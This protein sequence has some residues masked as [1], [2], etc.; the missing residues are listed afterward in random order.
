MPYI[1]TNNAVV[2][3]VSEVAED[4]VLLSVRNVN[5]LYYM[6]VHNSLP[7]AKWL[8]FF[9]S[10]A[11]PPPGAQPIGRLHLPPRSD[12]TFAAPPVLDQ[13]IVGNGLFVGVSD[14]YDTYTPATDGAT[15][16]FVLYSGDHIPIT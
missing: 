5:H 12:A 15:T 1:K 8:F 13:T 10:P 2:V 14:T 3:Y 6:H 16:F 11:A 9:S 7:M 4:S